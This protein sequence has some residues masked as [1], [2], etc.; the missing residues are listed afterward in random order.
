[1][2][3]LTNEMEVDS[4]KMKNAFFSLKIFEPIVF[5]MMPGEVNHKLTYNKMKSGGDCAIYSYQSIMKYYAYSLV[6]SEKLLMVEQPDYPK[7]IINQWYDLDTAYF[8]YRDVADERLHTISIYSYVNNNSDKIYVLNGNIEMVNLNQYLSVGKS[9]YEVSHSYY[10]NLLNALS[11]KYCGDSILNFFKTGVS[12][13]WDYKKENYENSIHASIVEYGKNSSASGQIPF[14][15][16]ALKYAEVKLFP[17]AKAR[18]ALG[19]NSIEGVHG[20]NQFFMDHDLTSGFVHPYTN[21]FFRILPDDA[22]VLVFERS[23]SRINHGSIHYEKKSDLCEPTDGLGQNIAFC[24]QWKLSELDLNGNYLMMKKS[25]YSANRYCPQ[26]K[27]E[28]SNPYSPEIPIWSSYQQEG[29]VDYRLLNLLTDS[30]GGTAVIIWTYKQDIL[31]T[32]IHGSI[33]DMIE[34][35]NRVKHTYQV[36][37]TIGIYDAGPFARKFKAS[38]TGVVD[39]NHVN[40]FTGTSEF[41]GAGYGFAK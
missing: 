11:L 32:D 13:F 41:V 20:I 22:Y 9:N 21:N 5:G 12:K 26:V 18:L 3:A 24:R 19:I 34:T 30:D 4:I 31:F 2:D 7:Q 10:F 23:L 37:P 29:Y 35:A 39:F 1:M 36:D 16:K 33:G 14:K 25:K 17:R 28:S 8:Q 38:E 15:T 40:K 27:K 6:N